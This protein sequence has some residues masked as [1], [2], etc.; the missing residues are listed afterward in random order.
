MTTRTDLLS[1]A[2]GT[3]GERLSCYWRLCKPNVVAL[4]VFTAWVGMLL[5]SPGAF[6]LR[7]FL[8]GTL[9]IALMAGAAAAI[10]QV[11]ERQVDARMMRTR[12]RPIPRGQIAPRECVW[13]A[14]ATGASGFAVLWLGTNPLTAWLTLASLVGYALIYTLWLKRATPQ[15]IVIGGAAGAT[16]PLLGWTAVTGQVDPYALVLFLI[17]FTW[18]PPHF[19]ALAIYRKA[20]YAK[21]GIPMLPVTHGD[22]HTR[23]QILLYTVLLVVVSLLPFLLGVN[24]VVYVVGALLLGAAFLY[25]VLMM[26]ITRQRR[27]A[28]KTFVFSIVYLFTL[29]AFLIFD[30]FLPML[31]ER[32][33][34]IL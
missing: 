31:L 32:I 18:T 26:M 10:N 22:D 15:N 13:F 20:D 21:A 9:G 29:F 4:M 34:V 30:R 12:G 2:P 16:P 23:L 19:W 5:A 3:L 11:V 28:I 24:G 7:A 14:L 17:I 6:P 27:W 33:P 8:F 25:H 1:A